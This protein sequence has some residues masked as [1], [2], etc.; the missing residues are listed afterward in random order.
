MEITDN[1]K[2]A[3]QAA[4]NKYRRETAKRITLD[5]SKRDAALWEQLEAQPNKQ[6]YIKALIK[7]DMGIE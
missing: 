5:F 2:A 3:L 1:K 7:R 4:K 6:G